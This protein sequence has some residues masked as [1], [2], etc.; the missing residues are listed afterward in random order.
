MEYFTLGSYAMMGAVGGSLFNSYTKGHSATTAGIRGV[1]SIALGFPIYYGIRL[2]G[3][4]LPQWA[5]GG[6]I[7]LLVYL[8]FNNAM[9]RPYITKVDAAEASMMAGIGM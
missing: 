4:A 8:F 6:A 1:E 2:S 9:T 5:L 3:V 7:G